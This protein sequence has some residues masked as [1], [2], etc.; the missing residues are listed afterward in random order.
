[1][2]EHRVHGTGG[3]EIIL[4]H[5]GPGAPGHMAPLGRELSESFRCIEPFQRRRDDEPL[6]VAGHIADLRVVVT[7]LC[8][9]Q[10]PILI[11]SSWG[12][13][14][15]LAFA[16]EHPQAAGPIVLVGCGTFDPRARAEMRRRIDERTTP[17]LREELRALESRIDDADERLGAM[18]RLI[19]SIYVVDPIAPGDDLSDDRG[20]DAI[21]HKE[22]WAD[23]LRLQ[24]EDVYPAAFASIDSPVLML[25]GACDP[26]PGAMIRDSLAPHM[27]DLTY[28]EWPDCGHY[29][30][31]DQHWR[32]TFFTTLRAWLAARR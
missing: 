4:L 20:F 24:A 18:G 27:R 26:H 10:A 29:P 17:R 11:G 16:A 22:T 12:A 32:M 13:M 28:I 21:G 7:G 5:G 2:L 25:H 1:M 8:R 6:S 9:S 3:P 31:R 15:A 30:W 19:D 23:M 14:L